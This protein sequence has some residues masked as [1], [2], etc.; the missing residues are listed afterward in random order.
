MRAYH[1]VIARQLAGAL[2][3]QV[4]SAGGLWSHAE[5]PGPECR[6]T[7]VDLSG[8]MLRHLGRPGLR[9]VQGDVFHLPFARHS[10]DHAVLPLVL[11]HLAGHSAAQARRG[12]RDA[13]AAVH[14]VLRPGGTVWISELV[15]PAP[16]Y[17]LEL[18]LVPLTRAV[19]DRLGSPL[20]V[21]HSRAFYQET[22]TRT[23]FTEVRGQ[24]IA[25]P[26]TRARDWI[27]P[28]IG[29][30]TLRIPRLLF[31]LVPVLLRATAR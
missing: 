27:Q 31:P 22:L 12:V 25:A 29:V 8:E 24:R 30:P 2:R 11:H 23:G 14:Q 17:P 6:L 3:G 28:I 4:L 21:M 1:Q 20:V 18:G 26:G 15:V 16:L 9:R 5:L 19:L 10:F 13:L 7:V